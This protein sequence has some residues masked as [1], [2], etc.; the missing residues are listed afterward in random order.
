MADRFGEAAFAATPG[1]I[2]GPVRSDFGYHLIRVHQRASQAVQIADLAFSLEPGQATL[3]DKQNTL[4]DVAFYAGEDRS[5][6]EEADS[7]GLEVNQVQAEADQQALPGIG[8]SRA[9]SSFMKEAE[10]GAISDV[11]EV[12]DKF[13]LLKVTDVKPEGYRP[14]EEVKSQ[15]RP[16]VELQKK[17]AVQARRMR[18]ALEQ[19]RFDQLPQV[20]GTQM[21]S[22][23]D[24]T[25]STQTVPGVG[26]DPAFSG[27]V[28]GLDEGDTSGVVEG[29]NAAFVVRLNA[30]QEPPELTDA[31][32]QQIRQ[33][34]LKQ[35]QKQVSSQWMAALKEDATIKDQRS[36]FQ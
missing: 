4:E 19:N 7:R 17:K 9:F 2:V 10:T 8:S 33:Q 28:F 29:E 15:I 22:Q 20:L 36:D 14:F 32:R 1:T 13:V 18:R 26:R 31:K 23:S 6:A 12:S 27:T 30:L 11:I 16:Q 24:V 3:T 34:L 25:F 5:F 35:R 21:R